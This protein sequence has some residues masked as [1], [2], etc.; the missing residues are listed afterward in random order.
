MGG[1]LEPTL[2]PAQGDLKKAFGQLADPKLADKLGLVKLLPLLEQSTTE[3]GRAMAA[4]LRS[5]TGALSIRSFWRNVGRMSDDELKLLTHGM[6]GTK[7]NA[8]F[9]N[10]LTARYG[11]TFGKPTGWI[12]ELRLST[13][14]ALERI[15]EIA[16]R[17]V[18][19]SQYLQF[20]G[21]RPPG[22]S[23]FGSNVIARAFPTGHVEGNMATWARFTKGTSLRGGAG[24][25]PAEEVI[26]HEFMHTVHYRYGLHGG[27]GF[28]GVEGVDTAAFNADWRAIHGST[29]AIIA[30][31][32][33][34]PLS[35]VT[36]LRER[37]AS[38][39]ATAGDH[40]GLF[41]QNLLQNAEQF[42]AQAAALEARIRAGEVDFFPTEYAK[43]GGPPEDFA[44]SGML[45]F[46]NPELLKT[47]SPRR[48][49]FMR[50]RV[51]GGVVP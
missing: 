47:W 25:D 24:V 43:R 36:K 6:T 44:E 21:I 18:T 31:P 41:S 51:F 17:Y 10:F 16:P 38:Y 49:A 3:A 9:G 34:D 42:E 50:D 20:L 7:G 2:P 8:A 11:I 33:A 39:R 48:Y 15:R 23:R 45:Y 19:D 5:Q 26:I 22:A 14:R 12:P 27:Y 28:A 35:A 32:G 46:L 1:N 37:A 29:E 30:T 40:P 13:L 4:E